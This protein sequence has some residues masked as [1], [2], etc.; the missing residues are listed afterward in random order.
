[1]KR[2]AKQYHKL[3][4]KHSAE[5]KVIFVD[6]AIRVKQTNRPIGLKRRSGFLQ[7]GGKKVALTAEQSAQ[8]TA[9]IRK[10][11]QP[12]HALKML[13]ES[14]GRSGIFFHDDISSL[15]IR[16][17][18]VKTCHRGRQSIISFN[19][20]L[21]LQSEEDGTDNGELQNPGS[22]GTHKTCHHATTE[23]C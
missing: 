11:K 3:R 19:F 21:P 4:D 9:A 14:M 22:L 15:D 5:L 18:S 16:F 2:K 1:M 6:E 8:F 10:N 12:D 7:Y 13:L 23:D 17:S 20:I